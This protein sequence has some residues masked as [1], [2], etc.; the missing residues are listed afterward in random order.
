[1]SDEAGILKLLDGLLPA[2]NGFLEGHDE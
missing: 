1:V 2:D